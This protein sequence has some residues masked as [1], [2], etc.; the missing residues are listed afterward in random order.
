MRTSRPT[1]RTVLPV[2]LAGV[3][4]LSACADSADQPWVA[5]EGGGFVFNYRVAEAYY[6]V[7]IRPMRHLPDGTVIQ[8]SFE[9]PAGGPP[10]LSRFTVK[11]PELRYSVR[12]PGLTGIKA[13]RPYR[14]ELSVL[15][16]ATGNV[17]GRYEKSFSSS[18]DQS[19]LPSAPL[20]IGPG[21]KRNP[22]SD[23]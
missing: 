10:I 22:D 5:F 17:L 23:L 3:L 21:Y 15:E 8:V 12:T 4:L 7:N 19:E 16:A 13:H 6:G 11:G 1:N 20:V 18:A 14:V 9:D 2:A